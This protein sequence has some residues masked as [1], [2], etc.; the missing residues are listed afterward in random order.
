[1]KHLRL[2]NGPVSGSAAHAARECC[3]PY[4]DWGGC[5]AVDY[6]GQ[7]VLDCLGGDLCDL[8]Y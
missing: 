8:D 3:V 1:V 4:I 5:N 6:C 2:K 7:D